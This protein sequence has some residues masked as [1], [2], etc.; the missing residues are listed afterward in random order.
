M[1]E[2]IFFIFFTI[3]LF[4]IV[5]AGDIQIIS[6]Y[7]LPYNT[8]KDVYDATRDKDLI[9]QLLNKTGDIEEAHFEGNNLII[10]RKLYVRNIQ[11]MGNWSFWKSEI[12]AATGVGEGLAIDETILKSGVLEERLKR[13]YTDKGYPEVKIKLKYKKVENGYVDIWIY[14]NRGKQYQISSITFDYKDRTPT[15]KLEEK[16]IESMDLLGKTFSII[17]IQKG[18]DKGED[19]L[20]SLGFF[21]A[22]LTY[23]G[24]K[25]DG[26]RIFPLNLLLK[27]PANIKVAVYLGNKYIIQIKGI[28]GRLK[29]DILKRL[30]L[31]TDGVSRYTIEKNA[32]II[33]KY[34]K[35]IGYLD[36][37]VFYKSK[38]NEKGNKYLI[39]YKVDLGDLYKISDINIFTDD[40]TIYKY[41]KQLK[42]KPA[43]LGE[44]KK[45]LA[46]LE[47]LYE[48]K[49][50]L[51][52]KSKVEYK[53]LGKGKIK[54]VIN[55]Y[56]GKIFLIK[57]VKI[58]DGGKFLEDNEIDIPKIYKPEWLQQLQQKIKDYWI[59]KKGYLD[60][61]VLLSTE[62][63]ED[64]NAVYFTIIYKVIPGNPYSR[65]TVFLYG[66]KHILPSAIERSLFKRIQGSFSFEKLEN[67][68]NYLYKSFLFTEV[69]G[70]AEKIKGE[71]SVV[72][73]YVL[74][75]DK[76]GLIQTSIGVN[77]E[78]DFRLSSLLVLKNIFNYGFEANGY[79]NISQRNILSRV[80]FGSRIL[81]YK[82]A[83]FTNFFKDRQY[84]KRYNTDIEGYGI[85]ISRYPNK[86]VTHRLKL[87]RNYVK[88]KDLPENYVPIL[89]NYFV[90]KLSYHIF[91]DH[92]DNKID[93]RE[94]YIFEM[95][96]YK[97]FEDFDFYKGD[98]RFRYYVSA[99]PLTFTQRFS[100]GYI[101]ENL[102]DIPISERYFLGGVG[103][104]R[105]FSFEQLG[106]IHD[107]GGKS[108]VLINNDVRF[109]IY[110]PIKGFVF[111]DIGN[112]FE[113]DSELRNFETRETGGIG[114][115]LPTP[116]GAFIVDYAKKL[117]RKKGESPAR[118]EFQISIQ[119]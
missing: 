27:T 9:I 76:R 86:W 72:E 119:F 35:N 108:Y 22:I 68:M 105:G 96:L 44:I 48:S 16:L 39:S 85:D 77:S 92:R 116:A 57:D 14:I 73:S 115:Y 41:F 54:L 6:N 78:E 2:K 100:G 7:P 12:L 13:F 15:K 82:T 94:G 19:Y 17:T 23:E 50:Y 109:P 51:N 104:F 118:I 45:I 53:K 103:N 11:V 8:I 81:P 43:R 75:E 79:I 88:L 62:T 84:H 74:K 52:V 37:K 38:L 97:Y 4:N 36:A 34:L 64:K 63:T 110:R 114:L 29:R 40:K 69:R 49:G 60:V 117:D 31:K 70:F 25:Q 107:L 83:A 65:K 46:D 80:S 90:V 18:L 59:M 21:D 28:K 93:P 89:K 71:N 95:N 113:K 3:F 111:I 67:N 98:T 33:E 20:H 106:G 101:W 32:E 99:G 61:D 26:S 55:F 87:E 1:R 102:K 66:T 56:R 5:Y 91:D 47:K 24:Y 10:K 30:T 112:V 58:L 42:N